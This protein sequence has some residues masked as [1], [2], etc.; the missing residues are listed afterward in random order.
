MKKAGIIIPTTGASTVWKAVESA[1]SQTYANTD[2]Y[3][4]ADGIEY[5]RKIMGHTIFKNLGD[6]VFEYHLPK[7]TGA[8]GQNGHRIYSAFSFL[9]DADYLF[10]LDQDCWF[11]ENHVESCVNYLE[12]NN[13]DWCHSLRKI[14]SENGDYICN[15]DCES[16]GKYTP[17]FDYN[18]VDTNC[19][20]IRRDCAVLASPYFVGGF[21]HDRRYYQVLSNNFKFGC[22][23]KY[24]INYR[25]GGNN[26]LSPEF[27]QHWNTMSETKYAG[28]LP[29]RN[30]EV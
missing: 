3:L 24:T 15:D 19:Y 22:T 12:S 1:L 6:R 5:S 9:S 29:W 2:V 4:V 17:N 18:L 25:L 10:Y 28:N 8:N 23:G 7:N 26:M 27:F 14:V 21:G 20:C 16:L 30:D 13:L 11:D